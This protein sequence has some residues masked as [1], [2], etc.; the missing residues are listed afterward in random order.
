[1]A[2]LEGMESKRL[3]Q[4]SKIARE[5]EDRFKHHMIDLLFMEKIARWLT[6][7][8]VCYKVMF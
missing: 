2:D 6:N 8:Q 7:T 1:M 5:F 4:A 3:E